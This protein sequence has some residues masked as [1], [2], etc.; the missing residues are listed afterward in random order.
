MK[1]SG[2]KD[3]NNENDYRKIK[4][5]NKLLKEKLQKAEKINKICLNKRILNNKDNNIP[6]IDLSIIT[7]PIIY[8]L[9]EL[10]Y[11]EY[12]KIIYELGRNY[13]SISDLVEYFTKKKIK[14]RGTVYKDLKEMELLNIIEIN[15]K[16]KISYVR[17]LRHAIC[18]I[19]K[20]NTSSDSKILKDIFKSQALYKLYMRNNRQALFLQKFNSRYQILLRGIYKKFS[21]NNVDLDF[22]SINKKI[23]NELDRFNK[24]IPHRDKIKSIYDLE[25]IHTYLSHIKFLKDSKKMHIEFSI[26]DINDNLNKTAIFLRIYSTINLFCFIFLNLLEFYNLDN[27]F[28]FSYLIVIKNKNR[29]KI[30]NKY[31]EEISK[32]DFTSNEKESLKSSLGTVNFNLFELF[33]GENQ[34]INNIKCVTLNDLEK[35]N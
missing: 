6:T 10:Y 26:L 1:L 31:L 4:S 13:F 19:K 30:I 29:K 11:K 21:K 15:N 25:I 7:N 24:K 23:N 28:E 27:C 17:L 33:S 34:L 20:N 9:I 8:I 22:D 14:T 16:N 5:E 32:S 2:L 35:S 12:V 18:Y 3:I